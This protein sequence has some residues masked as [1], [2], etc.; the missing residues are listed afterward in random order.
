MGNVNRPPVLSIIGN[1]SVEEGGTLTFMVTATDPDGDQLNYSANN[2][3]SGATFDLNT[4]VFSWTPPFEHVDSNVNIEFTATD[5][6]EPPELDIEVIT[7]TVGNVNRAPVFAPVG[8]KRVN[9]WD[10]LE[11]SVSATDADGNEITYST[12]NLPEGATFDSATQIFIW[13]PTMNQAGSYTIVFY[14]TDNDLQDQKMGSLR[15]RY[16]WM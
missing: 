3:P 5:N 6:G 8:V 1:K 11:F 10:K 12:G 13:T 4:G 16:R 2:L 14:A 9:E 7:I 15:C